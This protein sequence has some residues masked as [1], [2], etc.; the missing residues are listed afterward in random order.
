M[1]SLCPC[2]HEPLRDTDALVVSLDENCVMYRGIVCH[3]TAIETEIMHC[4]H[5]GS[6]EYSDVGRIFLAVYGGGALPDGGCLR[7][8]MT[9]IRRKMEAAEMDIQ[10]ESTQRL[11]GEM[12]AYRLRYGN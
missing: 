2:C 3:L 10:I 11:R 9:H 6:P 4:L 12:N 7:T 8:H 5:Q 1:T